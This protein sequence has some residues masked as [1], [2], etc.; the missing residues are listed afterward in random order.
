VVLTRKYQQPSCGKCGSKVISHFQLP[1]FSFLSSVHFL[2]FLSFL[3][4]FSF[5]SSSSY[6][7]SLSFVLLLLLLLPPLL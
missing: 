6:F 4:F 2:S 3:L 5:L 7:L 1:F